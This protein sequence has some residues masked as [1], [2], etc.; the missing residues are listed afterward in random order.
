MG[1]M[2]RP[3]QLPEAAFPVSHLCLDQQRVRHR[4]TGKPR[5]DSPTSRS[6]PSTHR[7]GVRETHAV[8]WVFPRPSGKNPGLSPVVKAKTGPSARA[9]GDRRGSHEENIGA[10]D[11]KFDFRKSKERVPA[12]RL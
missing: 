2:A 8:R 7:S 10:S 1:H 9:E 4:R 11:A 5:V 3:R 6:Q 12:T